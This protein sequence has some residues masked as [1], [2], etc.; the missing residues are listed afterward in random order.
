MRS[1]TAGGPEPKASKGCNPL[2]SGHRQYWR[3]SLFCCCT[4]TGIFSVFL[5]IILLPIIFVKIVPEVAQ[6]TLDH[7][8]LVLTTATIKPIPG[9]TDSITLEAQIVVYET[10]VMS[11][12]VEAS[13]ATVYDPL[14]RKMG[15][16]GVPEMKIVGGQPLKLSMSETFECT[17]REVFQASIRE[18]TKGNPQ[19]WQL[20][21]DTT[22]HAEKLKIDV[23]MNKTLP[24]PAMTLLNPVVTNFDMTTMLMDIEFYCMSDVHVESVEKAVFNTSDHNGVVFG[25]GTA[26][27]MTAKKGYNIVK[28]VK[29]AY[30][31]EPWAVNIGLPILHGWYEGENSVLGMA[32]P[33]SSSV[34]LLENIFDMKITFLGKREKPPPSGCT[35]TCPTSAPTRKPTSQPTSQPTT[36]APTFQVT[37][38]TAAPTSQVKTA[39]PT[40][41]VKTEAPTA[42]AKTAAPTSQ[43]KTE[44][45]TAQQVTTEA[46][47]STETALKDLGRGRGAW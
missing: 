16:L 27:N 2:N 32:G 14:G 25:T 37:K 19:N 36:A 20:V 38:A 40:V 9:A 7:A 21:S 45:P 39:A 35:L 42:Q 34:P 15:T 43:A 8:Q 30:F 28:G 47:G 3:H 6:H 22:L 44:A 18:M 29:L 46:P 24:L 17:D 12:T 31:P 26:Y 1:S 11:G 5:A 13:K 4:A 23:N 10:G 41:G 33:V